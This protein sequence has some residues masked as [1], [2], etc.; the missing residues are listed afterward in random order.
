MGR[1]NMLPPEEIRELTDAAG[2]SA[3]AMTATAAEVTSMERAASENPHARAYLAPTINAFTVQLDSGVRQY[4][5]MVTA[6]A[7][8]VSAVDSDGRA[9]GVFQQRYR[10][11]LTD[12]T[13]RLLGWAQAFEE[14]GPAR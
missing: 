6:A 2:R 4:S 12:A 14:L 5:A 11:E 1:G 8:L 7:Q 13:D 10:H 3:A 9:A